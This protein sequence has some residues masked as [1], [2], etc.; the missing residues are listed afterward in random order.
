[1]KKDIHP[2]LN[3]VVFVDGDHEIVTRS[4]MTAKTTKVI[5]GVEHFVIPIEISSFTHPFYT[6]QQRIVDTAGQ[7]E[8]FMRRLEVGAEQRQR[9]VDRAE[10]ER[11]AEVEAKRKRRGLVPFSETIEGGEGQGE[12]EGEGEGE[13]QD[14]G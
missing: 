3:P 12:G 9:S 13:A 8:R 1:M 5:D 10:A 14:Q 2:Q 6:G 7:V 4:T 11:K